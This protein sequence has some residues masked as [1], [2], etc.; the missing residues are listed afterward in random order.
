MYNNG[1]ILFSENQCDISKE[2]ICSGEYG[3]GLD[4]STVHELQLLDISIVKTLEQ[5]AGTAMPALPA[6][7]NSCTPILP[8]ATA[9]SSVTSTDTTT[10]TVAVITTKTNKR[11]ASSSVSLETEQKKKQKKEFA[12]PFCNFLSNR[13]YNLQ[14]HI[15]LHDPNRVKKYPCA[16]CDRGFDRKSDLKRHNT[17]VHKK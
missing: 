13:K 11:K 16:E 7:D 2:L 8:T 15:V 14:T 3:H 4:Q 12:C 10:A 17:N 1:E 6:A 5:L 9:S